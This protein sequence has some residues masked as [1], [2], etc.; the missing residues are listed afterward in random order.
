MPRMSKDTLRR[1]LYAFLAG[2]LQASA[3]DEVCTMFNVQPDELTS[4]QEEQISA[5]VQDVVARLHQQ[6]RLP[7]G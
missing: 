1:D 3:W 5:V 6:G 2:Y 4:H 7:Q